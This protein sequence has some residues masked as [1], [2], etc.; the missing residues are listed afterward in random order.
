MK[1]FQL[2]LL[3]GFVVFLGAW[4][5]QCGE[6]QNP[7]EQCKAECPLDAV[8]PGYE[9]C[10]E[11]GLL[12]ASHCYMDCEGVAEDE[13]FALCLENRRV[14]ECQADEDCVGVPIDCC[15]CENGG[16]SVVVNTT[17]VHRV[18]QPAE[19]ICQELSCLTVFLCQPYGCYNQ[20]CG[21][22]ED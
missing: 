2:G 1:M 12:Y 18:T 11:N 3:A 21:F 7:V 8:G 9:Y 5:P 4:D 17:Y 14:L 16:E 13:T 10:G 19:E 22:V 15:G 6:T 20:L